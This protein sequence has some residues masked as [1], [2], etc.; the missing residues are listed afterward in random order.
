MA[1]LSEKITVATGQELKA[2]VV[3]NIIETAVAAYKKASEATEGIEDLI[4]KA[5]GQ[6]LNSEV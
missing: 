4:N 3:N 2:S 5:I 1:I 6:A